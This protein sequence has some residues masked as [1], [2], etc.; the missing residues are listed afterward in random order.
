MTMLITTHYLEEADLLC[1]RIAIMRRGK[2]AAI[3]DP[4]SLKAAI[5]PNATLVD[6]LSRVTVEET[7]QKGGYGDATRER[8]T[9]IQHG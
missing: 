1:D 4:A 5:G 7:E 6:V 3:G 2:I 8:R 9:T